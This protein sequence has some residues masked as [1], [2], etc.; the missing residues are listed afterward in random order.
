M[1]PIISLLWGLV[2]LVSCHLTAWAD[3]S[4]TQP[5]NMQ[6]QIGSI[7]T[8]KSITQYGIT[9][10]FAESVG[11]GQFV[12]GDYWVVDIG[13]GVKITNISPGDALRPNREPP[14]HMNGSMINPHTLIQGYD[15]NG[16]Y[17]AAKNVGLGISPETPLILTGDKS[18]V[19]TISNIEVPGTTSLPKTAAVLTSLSSAPPT[20]SFRPGISSTTKTL[21]NIS[22]VNRSRLKSLTCPIIK[23]SISTYANYVQMVFLD[24]GDDYRARYI[25]PTDSGLDNY[26]F[27]GKFAEIGLILNLDYTLAEKETLL[28][29]FIQ[30]G[31]D[32][33]SFIE[34]GVS[35]KGTFGWQPDGGNM[36]GKKFPILFSGIM[37]DYAP[38]KNIGQKSGDYLYTIG[39]GP[40]NEPPDYIYFSE[41][42][43]TFYVTQKDIDITSNSNWISDSARQ[44][45]RY[46]S[47]DINTNTFTIATP[48]QGTTIGPWHPDTR[49]QDD[50]NNVRCRPYR[51]NMLG[52]PEWGIRHSTSPDQS[53]SSWKAGYRTIGTG[54]PAWPGIALTINIMGYKNIWNHPAFFD[55]ADRYVAIS[56]GQPDP[57]GYEVEHKT[58]GYPPKDFILAMWNTYRGQY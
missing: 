10:T 13:S 41:D 9:W 43:Q 20:G 37:L 7:P 18:L 48:P 40:G 58:T 32:L 5:Q 36:N 47:F 44:S 39:Y 26:Y 34:G 54:G 52:M 30:V 42:C 16:F 31:I 33:Y 28:I 53:D 8:T 4:A 12:N 2:L 27:A 49:N 19:S 21:H 24:H 35:E 23:P 15:G 3:I 56:Q 45:G 50:S 51:P 22:S 29:N 17:D 6:L 55:Y 14:Q 25:R 57:F 1:K 46:L 11:Y 38:M